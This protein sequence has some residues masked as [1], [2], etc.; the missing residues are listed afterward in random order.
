MPAVIMA[1]IIGGLAQAMSSLVGRVLL[2]LGVAF[3]SYQ[4]IDTL[5]TWVSSQMLSAM[6][7]IPPVLSGWLATLKIGTSISI[8][9]SAFTVRL[10][11]S[12]VGG[13]I[14]RSVLK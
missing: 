7:G 8:I 13:T 6:G 9:M 14:K 4:G 2:A 10:T 1:A 11:I 3:I 12:G 5:L